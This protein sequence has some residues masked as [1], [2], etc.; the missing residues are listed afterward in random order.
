MNILGQSPR[1]APDEI[2]NDAIDKAFGI[3]YKFLPEME[4]ALTQ[5]EE[6]K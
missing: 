4:E 2:L 5:M 3:L 6:Q 1:F